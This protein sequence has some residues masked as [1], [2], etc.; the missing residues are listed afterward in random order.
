MR[1]LGAADQ[2]LALAVP[3][4]EGRLLELAPRQR[5]HDRAVAVD[6]GG[7]INSRVRIDA[8]NRGKLDSQ[9]K[10]A[11]LKPLAI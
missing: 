5:R 7:R 6:D 10:R 4:T 11:G 8:A 3:P 1:H 9:L 2:V